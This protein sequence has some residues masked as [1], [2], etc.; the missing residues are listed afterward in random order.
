MGPQIQN[1]LF[2]GFLLPG[3][4]HIFCGT[5][6]VSENLSKQQTDVC[7]D[8]FFIVGAFFFHL[9]D[10]LPEKPVHGRIL[11][12]RL[13]GG[14]F[15]GKQG[16]GKLGWLN[17]Q[18]LIPPFVS[19]QGE[20]LGNPPGGNDNNR[21]ALLLMGFHLKKTQAFPANTIQNF[22]SFMPMGFHSAI[23]NR[24]S[25][26]MKGDRECRVCMINRLIWCTLHDGSS[27]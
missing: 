15:K 23:F 21:P 7:R 6:V 5:T 10:N 27:F 16:F 20:S 26:Q 8:C 17:N 1:S 2:Y 12:Y 14:A 4:S 19:G 22:D 13:G 18:T 9:S 25:I 11:D 24:N 3:G